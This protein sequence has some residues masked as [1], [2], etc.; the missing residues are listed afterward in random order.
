VRRYDARMAADF[1]PLSVFLVV[2]VTEVHCKERLG[3][4]LRH[5]QSAA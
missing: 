3:G 4:L 2:P 5:Y 1:Y